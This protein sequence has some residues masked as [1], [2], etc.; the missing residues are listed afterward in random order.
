MLPDILEQGRL[1]ICGKKAE[2]SAKD[3]QVAGHVHLGHRNHGSPDD[4]SGL[5][6]QY[7]AQVFL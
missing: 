2:L 1:V 6:L 7:L 4:V 3:A 5:L